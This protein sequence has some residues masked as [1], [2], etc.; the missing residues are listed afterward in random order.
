MPKPSI[1]APAV[2][3]RFDVELVEAAAGEDLHVVQAGVVEDPAAGD[4][5]REEVTAVEADG[6]QGVACIAE[7]F[8]RLRGAAD[9]LDRVVGVD[10]QRAR[11]REGVGVGI[12][13]LGLCGEAGDE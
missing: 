3:E 13:R 4:G 1:G 11:I 8:A 9:A 6:A 5:E 7:A 12:E 10:E 2:E